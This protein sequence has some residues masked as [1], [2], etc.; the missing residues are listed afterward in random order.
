LTLFRFYNFKKDSVGEDKKL[1]SS[2]TTSEDL[3]METLDVSD[4]RVI[5]PPTL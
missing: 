3:P 5:L 2:I 4:G 1:K